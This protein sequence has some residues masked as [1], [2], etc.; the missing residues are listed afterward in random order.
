MPSCKQK[1]GS[2]HRAEYLQTK[3]EVLAI[4]SSQECKAKARA[5]YLANPEKKKASVCDSYNPEKK[6]ASVRESYKANPETKKASVCDSYK[7]KPEK[8][9]ASV[10]DS[11]KANPEKKKASVHDSYNA[12]VESMRST[13]IKMTL[14]K[15]LLLKEQTLHKIHMLQL[16]N[17]RK[18]GVDSF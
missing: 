11:Y 12:D 2:Q 9:Q 3:D 1:K 6:K 18:Y 7:A 13:N 10:H 16:D 17:V 14:M 15:T 4:K 5:R 8:M